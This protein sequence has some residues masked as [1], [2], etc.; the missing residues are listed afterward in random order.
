MDS[1]YTS[2]R[3]A[4][5]AEIQNRLARFRYDRENELREQLEEQYD[6]RKDRGAERL[7]LEFNLVRPQ[8]GRLLCPKLM[9][10]C[11]MSD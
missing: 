9:L 8:Q 6:S 10:D 5:E 3:S 7:E 2:Y 11:A 4:R 1:E